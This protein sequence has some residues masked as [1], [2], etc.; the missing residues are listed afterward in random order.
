MSTLKIVDETFSGS[1]TNEIELNFQEEEVTIRE[2][3]SERVLHEVNDY[4]TSFP[5]YYR[6]LI[7]PTDAE[8]TLNGMRLHKRKEIDGEKQVYVALDAFQ[9]NGFFVLVDKIQADDLNMK[10]KIKPDTMISF[11]KLTPLVG[12]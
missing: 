2:I 8:K 5:E 10:V 9:K 4:N 12:G 1:V 11:I 3:I 6:G 7:D